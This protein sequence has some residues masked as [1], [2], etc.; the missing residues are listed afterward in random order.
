M[1]KQSQYSKQGKIEHF[2]TYCELFYWA[3]VS[4]TFSS[5]TNLKTVEINLDSWPF[6][7]LNYVIL[8]HLYCNAF[9]QTRVRNYESN[10]RYCEA[11]TVPFWL[12]GSIYKF[13]KILDYILRFK[14]GNQMFVLWR[15]PHHH[16]FL[17][18]NFNSLHY[19]SSFS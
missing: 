13:L 2:L 5:L 19:L 17:I 15:F 14:F 10:S 18:G 4:R 1:L 11:K 3:F 12:S 7:L 6:L 16:Y 8:H 9:I